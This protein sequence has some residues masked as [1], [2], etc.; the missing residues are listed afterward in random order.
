MLIGEC[1]SPTTATTP[2]PESSAAQGCPPASHRRIP[3]SADNGPEHR[4]RLTIRAYR[5][6]RLIWHDSVITMEELRTYLRRTQNFSPLPYLVLAY[7]EGIDCTVLA[8]LRRTFDDDGGCSGET[9]C[10][11]RRVRAP[12]SEGEA[13][14]VA[15][16][17]PTR[18]IPSLSFARA[19]ISQL[20]SAA[21]HLSLCNLPE[22]SAPVALY[23]YFVAPDFETMVLADPNCPGAQNRVVRFARTLQSQF[24][25]VHL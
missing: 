19:H 21:P 18:P 10:S 16:P 5:D 24:G 23:A 3:Y 22:V 4:V 13:A 25:P 9:F 17:R 11:E 1:W 7:E 14:L 2:A 20:T 12:R 8:S 15:P 6:G